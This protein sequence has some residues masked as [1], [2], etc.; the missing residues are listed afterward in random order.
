VLGAKFDRPRGQ[1]HLAVYAVFT[2]PV[3]IVIQTT[4][5]LPVVGQELLE[6]PLHFFPADE[7]FP[8]DPLVMRVYANLFL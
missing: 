1:L 8:Y 2:H 4:L 3:D 5:T 6:D 7:P